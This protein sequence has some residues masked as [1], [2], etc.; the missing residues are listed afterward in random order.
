MDR[1]IRK[2]NEEILEKAIKIE[3]LT[4]E[5]NKSKRKFEEG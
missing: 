4:R 3:N 2:L 1:Q 5:I